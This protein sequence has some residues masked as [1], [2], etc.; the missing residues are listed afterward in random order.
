MLIK[1]ADNNIGIGKDFIRVRAKR[2]QNHDFVT[3]V[4]ETGFNYFAGI[5]LRAADPHKT[6][7]TG[8]A[9]FCSMHSKR[10]KIAHMEVW[11]IPKIDTLYA[12]RT[13]RTLIEL[14]CT[15]MS[16]VSLC[17]RHPTISNAH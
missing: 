15:V 5:F 17:T 4:S 11:S 7:H 9:I 16:F 14:W 10:A 1:N 13:R 8:A 3:P 12:L 2:S 6:S